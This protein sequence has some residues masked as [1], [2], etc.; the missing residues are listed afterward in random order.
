VANVKLKRQLKRSGLENEKQLKNTPV[1]ADKRVV[2][3][4]FHLGILDSLSAVKV[5]QAEK[6]LCMNGSRELRPTV[7]L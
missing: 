7:F 6:C 4:K 3:R 2:G 1:K 5:S